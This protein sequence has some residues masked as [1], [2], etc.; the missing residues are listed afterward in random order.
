MFYYQE[1]IE[2]WFLLLYQMMLIH[3]EL[4]FNNLGMRKCWNPRAEGLCRLINGRLRLGLGSFLL[5]KFGQGRVE[6]FLLSFLLR[7][8]L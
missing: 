5:L 1:V 8:F 4:A 7:L 3:E 6:G 2:L